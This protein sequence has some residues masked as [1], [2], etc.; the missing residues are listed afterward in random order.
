MRKILVP[1]VFSKQCRGAIRYAD[2]LACRFHAKLTAIHVFQPSHSFSHGDEAALTSSAAHT[3]ARTPADAEAGL[4]QFL[5]EELQTSPERCVVMQGDPALSIVKY[6]HNG[7]FDLIVMPTHGYGPFRRFLL[8]SVT[9][10]VLHDADCPVWTG[11]H[12]ETTPARQSIAVRRVMCAVD[13]GP[14]SR[15]V[16]QWAA[17]LAQAYNA[18]LTTVHAIPAAAAALGGFYFDPEWDAQLRKA[19]MEQISS[20]QQHLGVGGEMDVRVGHPP[21]AIRTAAQQK[22]A[23]VLVIGRGYACGAFGRLRANAY[24]IIRESPCPVASI[25]SA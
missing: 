7:N 23:D 15:A 12:M 13:L 3:A 2:A 11:P 1:V 22:G 25:A 20:L 4:K 14:H 16:M 18:E 5:N 8:G 9:A 19:A 21:A 24:G 10:K 6:A 17:E